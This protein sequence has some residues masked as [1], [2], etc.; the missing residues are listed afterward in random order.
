MKPVNLHTSVAKVNESL[1]Q[2]N[3][4]LGV[5]RVF[6]TPFVDGEGMSDHVKTVGAAADQH[7]G[8][9]KVLL[10]S[11]HH[12]GKRGW[13]SSDGETVGHPVEKLQSTLIPK[14]FAPAIK[15]IGA[16]R[17]LITKAASVVGDKNSA[18]TKARSQLGLLTASNAA[19]MN[20]MDF[21]SMIHF[22]VL[23]VIQSAARAHHAVKTRH[24]GDQSHP[25]DPRL[26]PAR[27]GMPQQSDE[28]NGEEEQPE[29][30]ENSN[31]PANAA[32][33]VGAPANAAPPANAN[34]APPANGL[35]SP[36]AVISALRNKQG[37]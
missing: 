28:E 23:P 33:R 12:E 9:T 19:Q 30:E 26:T 16:T 36:G 21:C 25:G 10:S 34:S 6:S 5:R 29:S 35:S 8:L 4:A 27:H 2:L 13:N 14:D 17:T 31:A 15:A 22:L 32:P 20:L 3:D 18:I 7:G 24:L 1:A 37:Q 11:Y